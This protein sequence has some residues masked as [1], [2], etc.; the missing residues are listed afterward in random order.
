M[1][2]LPQQKARLRAY[3]DGIGFAR[4]SAIYGDADLSL[5]RRSIRA[6]HQA[7]IAQ[8]AAWLDTG[9]SG[10]TARSALDA[11]CG[12]GLFTIEL[13]RRNF[14]VRAV[15][16]APSMAAATAAR[17]AEAGL[18]EQVQCST[19]DLEQLNER[20]AV[21]SCFDVLIHY[22]KAD[23]A[24]L[25]GHL[26]SL[27]D[28][29]LLFTYAP[30][31]PL[32]AALHRVGSFFPQGQRHTDIQMIPAKTVQ[33]A[34]AASGLRVRRSTPISRPFYHVTLVEAVKM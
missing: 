20:F 7:M 12:T 19:A 28:E 22:P 24:R 21:V 15:D 29:V 32:L 27:A 33:Q 1:L 8:A 30:Y 9:L 6:G 26:A 10:T 2:E 11:G 17:I 16:L 13:A 3:F 31:S 25:C 34:L 23:F 5:V 14:C 4:W 18:S